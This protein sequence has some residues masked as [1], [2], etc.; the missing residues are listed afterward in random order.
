MAVV[1]PLAISGAAE[2][3]AAVTCD[4]SPVLS[5]ETAGTQFS[6]VAAP[7]PDQAV[8]QAAPTVGTAEITAAAE[9][10]L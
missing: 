2:V 6:E 8:P 5:V 3:A 7:E 10:A 9:A 4:W 1:A